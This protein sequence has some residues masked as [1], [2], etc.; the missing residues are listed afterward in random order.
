MSSNYSV[1]NCYMNAIQQISSYE[2][3]I[4]VGIF[5]M[6]GHT[7]LH[8][9]CIHNRGNFNTTHFALN[10]LHHYMDNIH[11]SVG[12][13]ILFMAINIGFTDVDK[14]Y[15]KINI[16]IKLNCISKFTKHKHHK[17]SKFIKLDEE[18]TL[19]YKD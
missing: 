18:V 9:S 12:S 14:D 3:S 4:C 7:Y 11:A 10:I 16:F 6:N 1:N 19:Q 13:E 2:R 17:K 15:I 5:T 8:V